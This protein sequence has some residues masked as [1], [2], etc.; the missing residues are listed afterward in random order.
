[1]P[2]TFLESLELLPE[3]E[4]LEGLVEL[5]AMAIGRVEELRTLAAARQQQV[6]DG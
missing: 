1:M 6:S 5:R 2:E 4:N 3:D